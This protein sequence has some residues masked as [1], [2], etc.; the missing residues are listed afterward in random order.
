[1]KLQYS[2]NLT[3]ESVNM[4]LYRPIGGDRGIDGASFAEELNWLSQRVPLIKIRIN[5][6]GGLIIDGFSIYS[7]MRESKVPVDTYNDF[8]AAS[9]GGVIL[10]GGRR[11]YVAANSLTMLHEP[12]GEKAS[13]KDKEILQLMKNSL[14][15]VFEARGMDAKIVSDMMEVES[16]VEG[17]NAIKTGLADE[18]F[19]TIVNID[20]KAQIFNASKLYSISNNILKNED[21]ENQKIE[22]LT[23]TV[24]DLSKVVDGMKKEGA[25]KDKEIEDLKKANEDK[26]KVLKEASDKAAVEMVENA[27]KDGKVKA[28]QREK[29]IIDAKLAPGVVK[30]MLDAMPASTANRFTNVAG[31]GEKK[32]AQAQA[33]RESWTIRDYEEKDPEALADIYKND[34]EKYNE[35][36]NSYYKK[37]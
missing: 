14:V 1:M 9:M 36:Y 18:M 28:D 13:A 29:L 25:D 32:T 12:Q 20:P 35:M 4:R 11:R 26:D 19:A 2:N 34:L 16:W 30:N 17:K 6:P 10:Q 21:M 7:A 8:L 3:D 22:E 31:S 37:K 5:T 15:S 23:K 24:N 33:G 27:I